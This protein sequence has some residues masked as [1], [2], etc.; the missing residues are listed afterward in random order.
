MYGKMHKQLNLLGPA[1]PDS[2]EAKWVAWLIN[3]EDPEGTRLPVSWFLKKCPNLLAIMQEART[4][5]TV[6]FELRSLLPDYA[7]RASRIPKKDL[8]FLV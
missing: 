1:V 4:T 2:L 5:V 7:K 3:P 6:C 8:F